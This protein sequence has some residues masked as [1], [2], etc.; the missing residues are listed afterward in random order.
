MSALAQS[1]AGMAAL[2][3]RNWEEAIK[4]LSS[5][6]N[7]SKSPAWLLSRSTAYMQS[8]QLEKALD[9]AEAAYHAAIERGNDKSRSQMI[10]A[11]YR[12]AVVYMRMNRY[13]DSDCCAVWSQQL[14]KDMP[15]NAK[16]TVSTN[17]DENGDYKATLAEAMA[18]K[19]SE[20]ETD[21]DKYGSITRIMAPAKGYEVFW[22]KAWTWR[23]QALGRMEKLPKGDPGRKVNATRIPAKPSLKAAEKK[24]EAPKEVA[25]ASPAQ[26][27]PKGNPDNTKFR[28]QM[29]QSDK[30]TTLTL[31]LKFPDKEAMSKVKVEMQPNLVSDLKNPNLSS[32]LFFLLLV[33]FARPFSDNRQITVTGV[34]RNPSTAYLVPHAAIDPAASTFRVAMMKIEFTMVKAQSGKWGVWGSEELSKPD[35]VEST[36]PATTV[37]EPVESSIEEDISQPP[38][39]A[40]QSKAP[41]YPTS[42][43]TGPKNWDTLVAGD[44]DD[45]VDG[46][47]VNGFFKK[48]FKN[49]TPEQQRAMQ[50]SFIESNG[51]SLST[52]WDEVSKD[53]VKTTPPDGVEAKKW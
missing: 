6:I 28:T 52:D 23:S 3:A 32:F 7:E 42:S 14:A 29:Y 24:V 20:E 47:D 9:D 18:E 12:R 49:A 38:A 22:N 21:K 13:A 33:L 40:V 48:I 11:Q 34:P 36:Q 37:V 51:T 46:E 45:K 39:A 19:W 1:T 44:E 10:D 17:V 43:K 4:C 16:D 8:G 41:A 50:K 26:T 15:A 25:K 35:G 5:A 31:L 53:T 30:S 27:A 2:K